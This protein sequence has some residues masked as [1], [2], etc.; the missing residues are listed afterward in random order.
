MNQNDEGWFAPIEYNYMK[1]NDWRHHP[2]R[3]HL[4]GKANCQKNG[5]VIYTV[6]NYC[7]DLVPVRSRNQAKFAIA[8]AYSYRTSDVDERLRVRRLVE[9]A[10][11][12]LQR[13]ILKGLPNEIRDK[14]TAHLVQELAAV[15]T[16]ETLSLLNDKSD[17][18]FEEMLDLSKDMY[19]AYRQIEGVTYV[20][21][22]SNDNLDGKGVIFYRARDGQ[23]VHSLHVAFDH[24]GI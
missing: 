11:R 8:M 12:K 16:G 9:A 14:V 21:W 3:F 10:S 23:Q 15:S 18:Y 2:P 6:H 20:H 24:L 4:C 5:M 1:T 13:D 7:L 19:L 17:W 22:L